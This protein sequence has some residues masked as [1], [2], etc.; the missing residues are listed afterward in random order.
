MARQAMDAV[1]TAMPPSA[2]TAPVTSDDTEKTEVEV[3]KLSI[4]PEPSS[5]KPVLS[6]PSPLELHIRTARLQIQDQV[7][8]GTGFVQQAVDKYIKTEQ[9]VE[10]RLHKLSGEPLVPGSLYVGIVTLTGSILAR[11]R[12]IIAR[13]GLPSALLVFSAH[14]FLPKTTSNVSAYL[15]EIEDTYFP[16]VAQKHSVANAHTLMTL[17]KI[18]N[19]VESGREK[20][21]QGIRQG[22]KTMQTATG[23]KV[24]DLLE[25]NKDKKR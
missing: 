20:T 22:L 7:A 3:P 5:S 19:A 10:S 9:R 1:Q 15:G 14:Y 6:S 12:G 2:A 11:N 4:Y 23:L 8:Q 18:N 13:V 16:V 21:W 25:E 24:A 17:D